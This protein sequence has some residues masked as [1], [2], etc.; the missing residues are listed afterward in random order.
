MSNHVIPQ[1]IIPQTSCNVDKV[2]SQL[3]SNLEISPRYFSTWFVCD[4]S[5]IILNLASHLN[6]PNFPTEYSI[7]VVLALN[8][9]II[10]FH[11]RLHQLSYK[12]HIAFSTKRFQW[13]MSFN[14]FL[15]VFSVFRC[16]GMRKYC[17]F[18]D[19]NKKFA[20]SKVAT[21]K[22]FGLTETISD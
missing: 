8:R 17:I 12:H 10:I 13:K 2:E 5:W 18:L 7:V 22:V 11:C 16:C 6:T 1:H 15:I 20:K 9:I 14:N 4:Y 3:I 19:V 21:G